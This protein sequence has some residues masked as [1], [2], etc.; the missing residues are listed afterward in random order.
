M[1]F[2]NAL[3]M[4]RQGVNLTRLEWEDPKKFVQIDE[5]MFTVTMDI[6]NYRPIPYSF[7]HEDLLA[8]DWEVTRQ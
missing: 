6:Y 1:T 3:K 8:S 4:L 7:S 5:R 2:D